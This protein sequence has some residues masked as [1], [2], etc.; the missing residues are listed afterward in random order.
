MNAWPRMGEN[1]CVGAAY[2]SQTTTTRYG[3]GGLSSS[4]AADQGPFC[5][6]AMAPK[7]DPNEIKVIYVRALPLVR[8][9]ER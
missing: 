4:S 6:F 9:F 3:H 8:E 7:I 5:S 2:F 1:A